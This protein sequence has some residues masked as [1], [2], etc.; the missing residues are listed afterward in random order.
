MKVGDLVTLS[1]YGE[2][3]TRMKT[4]TS[5]YREKYY[6]KNPLMGIIVGAREYG[7]EYHFYVKW[8]NESNPQRAPKS[9]DGMWGGTFDRKDL[10]YIRNTKSP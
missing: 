3:L 6:N 4:Y 7:G 8:L 2:Q 10:K 1:A 5:H 9:R